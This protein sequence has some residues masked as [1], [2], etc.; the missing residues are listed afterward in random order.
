MIMQGPFYIF[1]FFLDQLHL[2]VVV[3]DPLPHGLVEQRLNLD[4]DLPAAIAPF[5]NL[6]N[7]PWKT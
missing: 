2:T 6:G 5:W 3:H 1:L 7:A 4:A